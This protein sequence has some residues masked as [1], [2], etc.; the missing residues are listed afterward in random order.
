VAACALLLPE[1]EGTASAELPDG[2]TLKRTVS[3]T[4]KVDMAQLESLREPLAKL[5]VSLDVLIDWKPSLA[6]KKYRELTAEARA[7]VDTCITTTPNL[8]TLD[9]VPP[10]EE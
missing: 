8:P 5:H 4:R 7:V 2:W 1:C 10:K 6:T 3:Y 9:L